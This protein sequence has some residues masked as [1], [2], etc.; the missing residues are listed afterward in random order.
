MVDYEELDDPNSSLNSPQN[1][2]DRQSTGSE[3]KDELDD[4][5]EEDVDEEE[6]ADEEDQEAIERGKRYAEEN[7]VMPDWL[8]ALC[9]RLLLP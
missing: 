1:R 5:E 7:V 4:D 9:K 6:D 2:S 8:H 3:E